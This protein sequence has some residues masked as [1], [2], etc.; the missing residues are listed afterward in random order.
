M[1]VIEQQPE[2]QPEHQYAANGRPMRSFFLEAIM[3]RG[4]TR[5]WTKVQRMAKEAHVKVA[6]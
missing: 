1:P 3:V 2:C 6:R 5:R 4:N